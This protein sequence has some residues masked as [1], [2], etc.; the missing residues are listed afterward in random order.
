MGADQIIDRQTL[1]NLSSTEPKPCS[2]SEYTE[3]GSFE[4]D[5]QSE[6]D[7]EEWLSG[8]GV[9]PT[10][11]EFDTCCQTSRDAWNHAAL[12]S[13]LCFNDTYID[14]FL[15]I[16][17]DVPSFYHEP[18]ENIHITGGHKSPLVLRS[19]FQLETTQD[20]A[21]DQR[22]KFIDYFQC[23]GF[24]LS[25]VSRLK[26]VA[27]D[28][29]CLPNSR[30]TGYLTSI[31]L[32]WS[33]I[34]SCRW[35]EILQSAGETCMLF[36]QNDTEYTVGFWETIN[37]NR[38]SAQIKRDKGTWFSPW[39]LQQHNPDL[40]QNWGWVRT[41]PDSALAFDILL[42]FCTSEQLEQEFLVGLA[43]VLLLTSRN[44]PSPR[45]EPPITISRPATKSAQSHTKFRQL[46][47]RID[48]CM[49]LSATQDALE[50]LLCSAFFN[51]GIPCN[52]VGAES[53]GIKQAL[54][55]DGT[56]YDTFL[57]GIATR[58]PYL[59][60]FWRA[61]VQNDQVLP[62]LNL[63][64]RRLPPI[65]LV[66]AFWT[67][68][69][70]SFLQVKYFSQ[71]IKPDFITRAEEFSISFYCRNETPVPWTPSPPF[72]V[73]NLEN[74]SLEIKAHHEHS[75][76][77]RSWSNKWVLRS[78][79]N[80][81]INSKD[82]IPPQLFPHPYHNYPNSI[83]SLEKPSYPRQ[84]AEEQSWNATS[85]LFNWHRH[86]DDG[87]W[88]DDGTCDI[89]FI[90]HLQQH[91]WIVDPFDD[92]DDDEC[93]PSGEGEHPRSRNKRVSEWNAQVVQY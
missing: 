40:H 83:E 26:V 90:R 56:E 19:S 28:S 17:R 89:Q 75:H 33:Y 81:T 27:S 80:V 42:E 84:V 67:N 15:D 23:I 29:T 82:Q 21:C 54:L 16:L 78:G 70:Q 48:K 11:A 41:S 61:A 46:F 57:K 72:G 18:P 68:T 55:A 4:G 24:P 10:T 22:W 43:T 20:D 47:K 44:T 52:L 92:D 8:D 65:C 31:T 88:L 73:T 77:P 69:I 86:Y 93:D 34:I 85:R 59:I 63:A 14:T 25:M 91:P 6:Q 38:W 50:S 64:L 49:S 53:F 39:M 45:M 35:V 32:A 36:H 7:E 3:H 30:R 5:T 76:W 58:A 74:L 2:D 60:F 51:P 66:A 37:Q 62:L 12:R 87:L 9:C 13:T 71:S 79:E 1:H